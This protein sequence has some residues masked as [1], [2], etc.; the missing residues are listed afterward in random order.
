MIN[1]QDLSSNKLYLGLKD[2]F[3]DYRKMMENYALKCDPTLILFYLYQDK[4]K[5]RVIEDMG[6]RLVPLSY[7]TQ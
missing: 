7:V 1:G 2:M 5:R 6:D 3:Q 4:D